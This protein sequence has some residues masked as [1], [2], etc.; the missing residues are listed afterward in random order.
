MNNTGYN[1]N[2]AVGPDMDS[3]FTFGPRSIYLDEF[4]RDGVSHITDPTYSTIPRKE[5]D[6]V[7]GR[8]PPAQPLIQEQEP[9]PVPP[10]PSQASRASSRQSQQQDQQDGDI[11]EY[12]DEP[13]SEQASRYSSRSQGQSNGSNFDEEDG[14]GKQSFVDSQASTLVQSNRDKR[15]ASLLMKLIIACICLFFFSAIAAFAFA[16][17]YM[18][19]FKSDDAGTRGGT[20]DNPPT[21]APTTSVS[22]RLFRHTENGR[23][24]FGVV[25]FV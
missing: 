13:E 17:F 8:W 20:I 21:E 12:R 11:E 14:S 7:G 18:D 19:V 4:S 2:G 5:Y 22:W 10:S 25:H 16:Y 9:S 24:A 1:Q 23:L 3:E 6:K 15:L